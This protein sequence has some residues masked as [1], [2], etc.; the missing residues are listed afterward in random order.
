[1]RGMVAGREIDAKL[2]AARRLGA[3]GIGSAQV[4]QIHRGI[5]RRNDLRHRQFRECGNL[6]G[7]ERKRLARLALAARGFVIDA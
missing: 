2:H 3:A 7:F 1:M 4:E 5:R 6:D